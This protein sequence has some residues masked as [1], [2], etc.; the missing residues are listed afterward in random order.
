M[1]SKSLRPLGALACLMVLAAACA[2]APRGA[3]T[4]TV[5]GAVTYEG[6]Q[7]LPRPGAVVVTLQEVSRADAPATIV[8]RQEIVLT[9]A[10]AAPF[11][12][13]LVYEPGRIDPRGRYVLRAE[14]RAAGGELRSTTP[15]S[16]PVIP[17]GAPRTLD[18]AIVSVTEPASA[19]APAPTTETPATEAPTGG[20]HS[21]RALRQR[22]VAFRAVGNEPGWL[23]DLF[24]DRFELSY[25][26][27]NTTLAAPLPAPSAHSEG[28]TRYDVSAEGRALAILIRR[29]PCQDVM[30]GEMFPATVSVSVGDQT[31]QGC[32]RT[33]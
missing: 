30:S 24:A 21:D 13:T 31:L 15:Q 20:G 10:A 22:G 16:A 14:A 2:G 19:P 4:A 29:T 9:G 7:A 8:A 6:R 1:L 32:G 26:Y 23:L 12:F 27:G 25:D 5:T 28:V 33:P 11:P 17:Q 18:I 3:A